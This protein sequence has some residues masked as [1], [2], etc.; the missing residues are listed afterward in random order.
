MIKRLENINNLFDNVQTENYLSEDSN[1]SKSE[2]DAEMPILIN[3]QNYEHLEYDRELVKENDLE[4]D[5]LEGPFD[6]RL[7]KK[8]SKN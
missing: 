2:E 3:N 4:N 8:S 1:D 7:K 6:C 5:E